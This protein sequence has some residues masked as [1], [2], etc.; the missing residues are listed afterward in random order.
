MARQE[1]GTL[2][3]LVE[4]WDALG[5][6]RQ[7]GY[8]RLH[9]YSLVTHSTAIEGSSVT[10]VEN[11]VMFD[12]G[13]APGGRTVYEQSMNLDLKAAYDVAW[14]IAKAETPMSVHLLKALSAVVMRR[15]GSSYRTSHGDYD[16]SHGDFR[17]LNVT[18]G[19]DGAS[20][21]RWEKVPE[22][23]KQFVDWLN[24]ETENIRN[25]SV[26]D[27]YGLSFEVHWRLV[28]IHPWSDGNGRMARLVMNIVQVEGDVVPLCVR[29]SS[30]VGY[31][32]SLE[33]ARQQGSSAPFLAFMRREAEEVLREA[34]RGYRSS[35]EA[36]V[37]WAHQDAR[38][39]Q[40]GRT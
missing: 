38:A 3:R 22:R 11:A 24:G 17:L 33:E 19:P 4:E 21:L 10:F 5:I 23:T 1:A 8:E 40:R 13:I 30:R 37:P 9:T 35:L 20:Y 6:G 16:E 15:T 2:A 25:L 18:A 27:V 36:D 39:W 14:E 32:S 28:A 7:V 29:S 26:D 31:I 34:I 12:S